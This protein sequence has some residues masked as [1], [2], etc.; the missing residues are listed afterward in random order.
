MR[1]QR[2]RRRLI[3]D[4]IINKVADVKIAERL[5]ELDDTERTLDKVIRVCRQVELTTAHMKQITS[6]QDATENAQVHYM[7]RQGRGSHGNRGRG[8]GHRRGLRGRKDYAQNN[9]TPN[10]KYA[11]NRPYCSNCVKHHDSGYC[12]AVDQVCRECGQKGHF[13]KSPNC[14]RN[15]KQADTMLKT[16][17][18]HAKTVAVVKVK[19]MLNTHKATVDITLDMVEEEDIRM[20]IIQPTNIRTVNNIMTIMMNM[21]ICLTNVHIVMLLFAGLVRMRVRKVMNGLQQ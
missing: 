2:E 10:E 4:T 13:S 18:A 1:V 6:T 11:G 17:V 5:I 8:Q 20:Y 14:P 15:T 19:V 9:S 7:N 12:R 3:V 16:E 21:Q